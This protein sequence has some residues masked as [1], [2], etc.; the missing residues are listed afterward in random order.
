MMIRDKDIVVLLDEK[1]KRTILRIEDRARRVR[2]IGV[3][4]PSTLI[5]REF[6]SKVRIGNSDFL[7]LSPSITDRV[8]SIER[9][10]QVIL[11]KDSALIALHC[12]VR[13]GKVIIEGGLGSGALTIVLASLVAPEGRVISY[14]KRR[15]FAEFGS[16]NIENA[17]LSRYCEVKVGDVTECIEE[18]NADAVIFDIPNPWDAIENS[19]NALKPCG[20]FASYSPTMNQVEKTV[21][22]L[23]KFPFA[24]IRTIETLQREIV[25]HEQGVR[26]SFEMLGHTGYI[27]FARKVLE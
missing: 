5:G 10:A 23:R 4:N 1:G 20:H 19:Y 15:E 9:K 7:L 13:S 24:E 26:P 11:P 8:E 12:D 6:G 16:M 2:G 22:E 27:T 21:K 18:K 14:E 17:G 3:Y 25:V